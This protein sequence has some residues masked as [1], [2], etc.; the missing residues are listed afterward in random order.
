MQLTE[1]ITTDEVHSFLS[2]GPLRYVEDRLRVN[3]SDL[4]SGG[5]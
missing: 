3:P 1:S 4:R 5:F 2:E